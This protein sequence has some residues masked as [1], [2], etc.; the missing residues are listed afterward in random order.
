[1]PV[2][3]SYTQA[4]E[5]FD[6]NR[7]WYNLDYV[8][9]ILTQIAFNRIQYSKLSGQGSSF[10][11]TKLSGN[12]SDF[13]YIN[14]RIQGIE[15]KTIKFVVN[16]SQKLVGD[17]VV[18]MNVVMTGEQQVVTLY[19]DGLSTTARNSIQSVRIIAEPDSIASAVG[20]FDLYMVEF[21]NIALAD[22]PE[23]TVNKYLG[24]GQPFDFN[25]YWNGFNGL[26]AQFIR[27]PNQSLQVNYT[28]IAAQ[29]LVF[30][31]LE[32]TFSDFNYLNFEI[33][34]NPFEEF[35]ITFNN[36]Y[37]YRSDQHVRADSTGNLKVTM[38]L[39]L[40]Y[41]NADKN[42]IDMVRI[43]PLPNVDTVTSSFIIKKAEFSNIPL[44][45]Y[46]PKTTIEFD[47]WMQI[48]NIFT[49]ESSSK[50][51]SWS[52]QA[53]TTRLSARMNGDYT[54]SGAS[55][56]YP[57]MEVR[58]V[59]DIERTISFQVD[60]AIYQIALSPSKEVYEIFLQ[61]PTF[62]TADYWKFSSGFNL[63][64][65]IDTTQAGSIQV[66]S[67]QWKSITPVV[68]DT[69][70]FIQKPFLTFNGA[71][72]SSSFI[73]G[74]VVVSSFTKS[75]FNSLLYFNLSNLG[76]IVLSDFDFLNLVIES[77]NVTE[78]IIELSGRNVMMHHVKV[79]NGKVELT[80]SLSTLL[81]P[82]SLNSLQYINITPMPNSNNAT[83]SFKITKAEFSSQPMIDYP[84]KTQV[85]MED[86]MQIGSNFVI[87]TSTNQ[88]TW[89]SMTG[90]KALYTRMYGQYSN[91]MTLSLH[92]TTTQNVIMEFDI[93]GAR[94]RI[95]ATPNQQEYLITLL[96][97][98]TGNA[99][100]WKF[101]TGFNLYMWITTEV[102]GSIII[103]SINVITP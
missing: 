8:Y 2:I 18:E 6:A 72:A 91:Q 27:L 19:L 16:P 40:L 21:S 96:T 31:S 102:G 77:D 74:E 10:I 73:N 15:G 70:D 39:G 58:I 67:V 97:P 37:S 100:P 71:T 17:S 9:S 14:I 94:Y 7:G 62:G 44:V 83:G 13:T 38:T 103:N 36:L 49:M 76:G 22:R 90:S 33:Q 1:V 87:N 63:W 80:M 51:I 55:F 92:I 99:D 46:T 64:F 5:S 42:A 47:D 101:E 43:S 79:V 84:T 48:G 82:S 34:A 95:T 85:L 61:T 45:N 57:A 81:L 66:L 78:F 50:T 30:T 75:A 59:S 86:W 41:F 4:S 28:K 52:A 29:G 89:A 53:G 24:G 93:V 12:F 35:L 25:H 23:E 20:Y 3:Q 11:E 88:I 32:G 65:D 26:N 54:V 98:T 56:L 69:F 60:R 68:A